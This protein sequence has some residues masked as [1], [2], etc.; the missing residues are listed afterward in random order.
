MA[1]HAERYRIETEGT[2]SRQNTQRI[3]R[4]SLKSTECKR[5]SI[6]G[7]TEDRESPGSVR[8]QGSTDTDSALSGE[9][10]AGVVR[11][12]GQ[13]SS[14]T[15]YI[16]SEKAVKIRVV[17]VESALYTSLINKKYLLCKKR[18]TPDKE[19]IITRKACQIQVVHSIEGEQ[20]Y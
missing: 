4:N 14:G 15:G 18:R 8:L 1:V 12:T 20:E 17:R 10:T 7:G 3:L 9:R 19:G 11:E 13:S 5:D 16:P 6:I 2:E